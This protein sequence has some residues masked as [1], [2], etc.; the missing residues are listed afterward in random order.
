MDSNQ[1]LAGCGWN[2]P[3]TE[4]D[5]FQEKD[6]I[7]EP[8]LLTCQSP[9]QATWEIQSW[10]KIQNWKKEIQIKRRNSKFFKN[11]IMK[12]HKKKYNVKKNTMLKKISKVEQF[13]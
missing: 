5:F 2:E 13:S 9:K 3:N 11:S 4:S 8:C 6:K 1:E 12:I 10:K 7:A